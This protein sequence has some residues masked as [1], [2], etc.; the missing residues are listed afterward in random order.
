MNHRE[1]NLSL[2]SSIKLYLKNYLSS[3]FGIQCCTPKGKLQKLYEEGQDKLEAEM[4]MV[5]II[6]NLKFL[7]I[8][9]KKYVADEEMQYDIRHNPKNVIDL[10]ALSEEEKA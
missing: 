7:R 8:L 1:I 5:K 9:M 2:G 4:N 3:W 10:D 6:R